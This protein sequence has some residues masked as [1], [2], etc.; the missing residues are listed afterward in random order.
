MTVTKDGIKS[1]HTGTYS[2]SNWT[3]NGYAQDADTNYTYSFN[4]TKDNR[5]ITLQIIWTG[6]VGGTGTAT[7]QVSTNGI[8]YTTVKD[9]AGNDV[10]STVTGSA[11]HDTITLT[12]AAVGYYR[13]VYDSDTNNGGSII[14]NIF[15]G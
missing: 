9:T 1:L 14:V 13:I 12:G 5:N 6:T 2:E 3:A 15:E 7:L 10:V 11:D 4:V 8:D